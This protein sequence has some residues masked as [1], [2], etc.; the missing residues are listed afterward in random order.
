[1]VRTQKIVNLQL[2]AIFFSAFLLA[3]D[4]SLLFRFEIQIWHPKTCFYGI[5]TQVERYS[6]LASN[7]CHLM[8]PHFFLSIVLSFFFFP[9]CFDVFI[10]VLSLVHLLPIVGPSCSFSF[11]LFFSYCIVDF[12]SKCLTY[13]FLWSFS[14]LFFSLDFSAH[15]SPLWNWALVVL[16]LFSLK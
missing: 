5:N 7:R 15:F 13:F 1:M 11:L 3:F 12:F 4:I 2:I 14:Q 9:S 16:F 8:T 6:C 10:L